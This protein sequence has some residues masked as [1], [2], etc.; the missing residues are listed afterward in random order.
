MHNQFAYYKDTS[1]FHH[2]SG[3]VS[4]L[5]MCCFETQLMTHYVC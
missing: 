2:F 1:Q 5:Q 4:S 3:D